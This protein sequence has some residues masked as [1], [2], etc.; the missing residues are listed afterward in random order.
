MKTEQFEL[1]VSIAR[2]VD[3]AV[4][5]GWD[6]LRFEAAGVGNFQSYLIYVSRAGLEERAIPPFVVS[7]HL[8]ALKTA[9]HQAGG[10]TWVSLKMLL[11]SSGGLNIHYN[12]DEKPD[13]D[14]EVS[15]H[16]YS[17]ELERFPR[18]EDSIPAWWRERIARGDE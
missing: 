6:E 14:F 9:V 13:F 10:G 15:A 12:Y 3:A 11:S 7:D 16:D 5:P 17:L 8:A 1:E 18:A 2:E 4:S